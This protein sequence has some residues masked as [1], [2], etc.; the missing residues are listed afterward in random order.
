LW[1][2]TWSNTGQG[3]RRT[4]SEEQSIGGVGY[5]IFSGSLGMI[6]AM[7]ALGALYA[8]ATRTMLN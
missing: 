2:P 5:G 7:L 6:V 3:Y 8:F 1:T 4:A